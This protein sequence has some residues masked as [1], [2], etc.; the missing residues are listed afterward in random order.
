VRS[1]FKVAAVV[2]LLFAVGTA[3]EVQRVG[4]KPTAVVISASSQ[5]VSVASA[6][7][8]ILAADFA[9]L[10]PQ[11]KIT[12]HWPWWLRLLAVVGV[13]VFIRFV[14]GSVRSKPSGPGP[15]Q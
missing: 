14:A 8:A 6:R 1:I 7:G 3:G 4:D 10:P 9:T 5:V 2:V 13:L 15:V 11:E 12:H